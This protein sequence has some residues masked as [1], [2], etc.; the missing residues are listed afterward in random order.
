LEFL[1]Y[2]S[3]VI[4]ENPGI[5][6]NNVLAF[7]SQIMEEYKKIPEIIRPKNEK[8][9]EIKVK[10]LSGW[11]LSKVL[12]EI[13]IADKEKS[14]ISDSDFTKYL[15]LVGIEFTML[16]KESMKAYIY[17]IHGT[18]PKQYITHKTD[19]SIKYVRTY[20][21]LNCGK[22]F[23]SKSNNANYCPDCVQLVRNKKQ[24]KRRNNGDKP[25]NCL[26]C[27]K[28]LPTSKTKPK[29][30]CNDECRYAHRKKD[31]TSS[32]RSGEQQHV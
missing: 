15:V 18:F 25:E 22:I 8:D 7:I 27:Q 10:K 4:E 20:S 5:N 14:D 1:K 23:F 30:Y 11:F 24:Q 32:R 19:H 16:M 26:F 28:K 17:D 2:F 12:I 6:S 29:K 9:L 21:C 13:W 3:S 31:L